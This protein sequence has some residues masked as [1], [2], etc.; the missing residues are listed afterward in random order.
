MSQKI[1]GADLSVMLETVELE[2]ELD[3]ELDLKLELEIL[4]TPIDR[5]PDHDMTLSSTSLAPSIRLEGRS[6]A[7]RRPYLSARAAMM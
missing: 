6:R 5:C 1:V 7:M 4:C 3:L 2:L